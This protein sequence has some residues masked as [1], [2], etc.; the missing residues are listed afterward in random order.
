MTIQQFAK[1]FTS[2]E[3]ITTMMLRLEGVV[4]REQAYIAKHGESND[5]ATDIQWEQYKESAQFNLDSW[6][7]LKARRDQ[8]KAT[9]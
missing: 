4:C 6:D 5:A 8:I 7:A 1:S 2:L 9:A 3:K